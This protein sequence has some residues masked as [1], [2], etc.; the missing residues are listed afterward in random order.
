MARKK[1]VKRIEVNDQSGNTLVLDA[2]PNTILIN[3]SHPLYI[4]YTIRF[5]ESAA[6]ESPQ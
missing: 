6:R 1:N 3:S 4:S 2:R 5:I